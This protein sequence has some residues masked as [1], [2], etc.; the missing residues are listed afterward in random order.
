M[1]E[2][3]TFCQGVGTAWAL[4]CTQPDPRPKAGSSSPRAK[5][6]E[7]FV[8]RTLVLRLWVLDTFLKQEPIENAREDDL[9]PESG[10]GLA[11]PGQTLTLALLDSPARP[12]CSGWL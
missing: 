5:A 10:V 11:E 1:I 8:L 3:A 6:E 9:F 2:A 7:G 4:S 12:L